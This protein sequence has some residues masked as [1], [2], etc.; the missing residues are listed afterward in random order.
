M[1]TKTRIGTYVAAAVVAANAWAGTNTVNFVPMQSGSYSGH[2][3]TAKEAHAATVITNAVKKY[4]RVQGI[5][6]GK[7]V[8]MK[9]EEGADGKQIKKVGVVF[10][11]DQILILNVRKNK[12][13][14][15]DSSTLF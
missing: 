4:L 14:D 12:V 7:I 5:D 11:N 13:L 9:E 3:R 15:L 6:D 1:N 8:M 10:G 2:L